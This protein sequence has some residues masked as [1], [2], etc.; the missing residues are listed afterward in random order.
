MSYH[1]KLKTGFFKKES[2]ELEVISNGLIFKTPDHGKDIVITA[3][4]ILTI[5][6]IHNY[7]LPEIEIHTKKQNYLVCLNDSSQEEEI[8]RNLSKFFNQKF[9]Y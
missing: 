5:D 9:K 7:H 3:E 2:I 8:H 6:M 4:D 1:L